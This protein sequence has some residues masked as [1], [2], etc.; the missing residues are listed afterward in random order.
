MQHPGFDSDLV[1]TCP[2]PVLSGIF[3]GVESWDHE[4]AKGTLQVAGP[5]RLA[6]ALPTWFAWSP[7][8]DDMRAHPTT[9]ATIP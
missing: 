4:L 2:T 9:L 6:R 5:P 3:S 8:N 1:V 7:F